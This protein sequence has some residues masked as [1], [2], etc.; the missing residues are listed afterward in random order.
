[1]G[2][3][4]TSFGPKNVTS[5]TQGPNRPFRCLDILREVRGLWPC[6]S[7][8]KKCKELPSKDS[9]F[10]RIH[11]NLHLRLRFGEQVVA[12]TPLWAPFC[13]ECLGNHDEEQSPVQP[14][15][16]IV[17]SKCFHDKQHS[18]PYILLHIVII[19]IGYF[20]GALPYWMDIGWGYVSC[21][22]YQRSRNSHGWIVAI[23]SCVELMVVTRDGR[24]S[25]FFHG[26][27]RGLSKNVWGGAG[28][29]TPPFPT[30]WGGAGKGSKSA[31]RGGAGAGN[32]L[33]VSADWNHMLQQRKS[34]FA[35]H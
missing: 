13:P 35:L 21:L 25:Y 7:K 12:D 33:R 3:Q 32:I 11:S 34:Q 5:L 2:P 30:V 4:P 23:L 20:D 26:A 18:Y 15:A 8:P 29:G 1:M 31:G 22:K 14:P 10:V 9:F 6:P 17:I 24:G 16:K 19:G 28:R 27:G